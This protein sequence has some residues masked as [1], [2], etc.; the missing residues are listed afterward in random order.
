LIVLFG[1]WLAFRGIRTLGIAALVGWHDS[2]WFALVVMFVLR[3]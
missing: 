1:S 2:A 3:A